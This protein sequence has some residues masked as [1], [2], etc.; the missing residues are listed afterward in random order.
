[1]EVRSGR[2]KR[3]GQTVTGLNVAFMVRVDIIGLIR[4]AGD[5]NLSSRGYNSAVGQFTDL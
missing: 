5:N 1:M 2:L 4:A 3:H